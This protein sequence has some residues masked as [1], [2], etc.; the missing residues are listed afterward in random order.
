MNLSDFMAMPDSEREKILTEAMLRADLDQ[1]VKLL[2]VKMIMVQ[3]TLEHL[4]PDK[5]DDI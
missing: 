5:S 2:E 3:R 1:R 4:C